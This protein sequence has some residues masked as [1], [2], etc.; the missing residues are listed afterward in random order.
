[1]E[2]IGIRGKMPTS[3]KKIELEG[4]KNLTWIDEL[5]SNLET[6]SFNKCNADKVT[7]ASLPKT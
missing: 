1:L 4:L 7:M 3:L 5:P 6:L 2:E